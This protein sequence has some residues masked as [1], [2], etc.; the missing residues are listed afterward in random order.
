MIAQVQIIIAHT[1]I[2]YTMVVQQAQIPIVVHIMGQQVHMAI[3][4]TT[5][6]QQAQIPIVVHIMGQQVQAPTTTPMEAHLQIQTLTTTY[7]PTQTQVAAK[8]TTQ[9]AIV[10]VEAM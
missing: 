1:V 8:T 2:V 4:H 7:M 9:L 5:V 6:V 10:A 3:V